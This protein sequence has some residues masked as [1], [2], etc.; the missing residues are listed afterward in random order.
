MS[1]ANAPVVW[2]PGPLK[3]LVFPSP[4]FFSSHLPRPRF[5]YKAT[6]DTHAASFCPGPVADW[7]WRREGEV[8]SLLYRLLLSTLLGQKGPRCPVPFI[9]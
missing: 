4:G 7:H 3:A 9:V 6:V 2:V 1:T 5:L 8:E